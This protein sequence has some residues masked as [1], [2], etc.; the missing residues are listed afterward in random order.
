MRLKEFTLDERIKTFND[1]Q[2]NKIL[3]INDKI[4]NICNIFDTIVELENFIIKNILIE[5]DK[6]ISLRSKRSKIELNRGKEYYINQFKDAASKLYNK[7]SD[8]KNKW[9]ILNKNENKSI[10]DIN[11]QISM[12]KDASK[13][14]SILDKNKNNALSATSV[15]VDIINEFESFKVY[16]AINSSNLVERINILM[17]LKEYIENSVPQKKKIS[18]DDM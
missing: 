18:I 2:K 13:S 7:I 11:K 10:S 17:E 14:L 3:V 8:L 4:K 15:L 9:D 16:K 6:L 5:L 1:Q 12:L